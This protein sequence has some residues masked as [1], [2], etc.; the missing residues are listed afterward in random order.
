MSKRVFRPEIPPDAL[1]Q[2]DHRLADVRAGH[3]KDG[4]P[5]LDHLPGFCLDGGDHPVERCAK[6]RV[7]ELLFGLVEVGPGARDACRRGLAGLLGGLKLRRGGD[8]LLKQRTLAGFGRSRILQL[9]DGAR[10]LRLRRA[11]RKLEGDGV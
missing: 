1:G 11:H 5:R 10:Q 7:G 3:R 4:L 6:L 8:I 2:V 9:R